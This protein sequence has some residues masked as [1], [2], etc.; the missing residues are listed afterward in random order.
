MRGAGFVT[1]WFRR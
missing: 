1:L